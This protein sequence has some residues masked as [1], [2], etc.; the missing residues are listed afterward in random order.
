MGSDIIVFS[1]PVVFA[2]TSLPLSVVRWST[3]FGSSTKHRLAAATFAVEII[4]SLSG[5]F[6]VLLFLLTRSGL[7]LPRNLSSKKKTLG[8][9]LG[10][11]VTAAN[12][13]QS[14]AYSRETSF[15]NAGGRQNSRGHQPTPLSPL[16]DADDITWHLSVVKDDSPE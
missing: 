5:A 8:K 12:S 2:V 7:L 13:M 10:T 15:S 11:T 14:E 16:P 6:N 4:Y 9:A 3:A 1:Y